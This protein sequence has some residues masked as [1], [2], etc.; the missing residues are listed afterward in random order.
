MVFANWYQILT[1]TPAHALCPS[2]AGI[3]TRRQTP[4]EACH[5]RAMQQ[6]VQISS[7]LTFNAIAYQVSIL[8]F[9]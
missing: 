2:P 9:W 6:N 3:A 1:I 5:A 8:E 4:A 7:K